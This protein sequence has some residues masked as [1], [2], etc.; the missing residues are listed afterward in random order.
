MGSYVDEEEDV[1]QIQ[2]DGGVRSRII[3]PGI[4]ETSECR[5]PGES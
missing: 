5:Q 2:D 1:G 4:H 3:Q